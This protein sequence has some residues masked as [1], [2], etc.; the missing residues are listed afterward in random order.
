MDKI[1]LVI[2]GGRDYADREFACNILD[3]MYEAYDIVCLIHGAAEGAD[4]LAQY[5]ADH[6]Q[7]LPCFAV[8]AWWK[9][10]DKRAGHIRNAVMIDLAEIIAKGH[11]DAHT[12]LLAFPGGRGT[13]NMW[14]QVKEP[15]W[16]KFKAVEL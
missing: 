4:T 16:T 14:D 3:E 5:W 11:P 2:T 15:A 1:I 12:V 9:R 6:Q 8:P 7:G 10:Y 13:Q